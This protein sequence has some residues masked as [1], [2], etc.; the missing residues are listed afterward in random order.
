MRDKKMNYCAGI[1]VGYVS[2]YFGKYKGISILFRNVKF[3]LS[4]K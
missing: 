3:F 1:I 2:H 4:A